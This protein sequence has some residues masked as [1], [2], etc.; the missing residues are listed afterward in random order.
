MRKKEAAEYLGIST[1]ALEAHQTSGKL[2]VR[3]ERGKTGDVAV[4]DERE[5]KK[6][7]AEID[8]RRNPRPAIVSEPLETSESLE[9]I[10]GSATN[11]SSLFPAAS[12]ITQLAGAIEAARASVKPSVPIEAKTLLKLSE[13]T[14]LTGLSRQHLRTAI[15]ANKLKAK[16]IGRA[17]RIKRADIDTYVTKL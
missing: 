6:L 8:N 3:Y 7:R 9:V 13:A 11:L 17:W 10:R 14:S 12:L 16:L 15:E 4:Y 1:R 2:S 5:L